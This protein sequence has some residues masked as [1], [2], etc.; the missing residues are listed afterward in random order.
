RSAEASANKEDLVWGER[1]LPSK[2]DLRYAL[3]QFIDE[4]EDIFM[5]R[6]L[7]ELAIA[8]PSASI[9]GIEHPISIL[10]E[11]CRQRLLPPN[12]RHAVAQNDD[13]LLL[14]RRPGRRQKFGND[15]ILKLRTQHTAIV[16]NA[17]FHPSPVE[18]ALQLPACAVRL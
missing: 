13:S 2:S 7:E 3:R 17:L 4:V 12:G 10:R 16:A 9:A 5:R 1:E 15:L 11:E 18:L 14:S 6:P 8:L